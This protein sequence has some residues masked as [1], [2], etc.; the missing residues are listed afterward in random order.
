MHRVAVLAF[1][2]INPFHL[3]VAPLVLANPALVA[4]G[5][6][7]EVVTVAE[8]P[9]PVPTGAGYAVLVERDLTAVADADTVVIPSWKVD[10]APSAAL[11]DVLRGAHGRGARVV[12]LCLGA[13]P[14]AASGVADGREVATHWS[15]AATLAARYPAVR[16][17]SDVLW[18]DGG[19][20][21]TSAG[22]AAALD[23]CLHVVRTD[24][25]AAVAAEVA[26]ALVLA[27]HREG[28]QA[29]FVPA[30]VAPRPAGDPLADAMTWALARLGERIGLDAWA[31]HAAMSRRTFTRQFHARTGTS[32]GRW[33]LDQRLLRA[34]EL[35]E[36]TAAPV[37][38]VAAAVG[39]AT[40]ASLR[41]HFAERFGTTPARHRAAFA[42]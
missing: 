27:P 22:V 18:C 41:Q 33:L 42:G 23:C 39:F 32:P 11:L 2:G 20:V 21:V 14:V 29:Q 25:G 15:A 13:F 10:L 12:G 28:S 40:A 37:D 34:K 6:P 31:R 8:T 9:G 17:R 4:H 26:R 36:T 16:V 24:H 30:P 5:S 35:L 7:Y 19:D 1:P 38:V 3:S